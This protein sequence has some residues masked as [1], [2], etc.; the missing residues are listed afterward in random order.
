MKY[1]LLAICSVT[2]TSFAVAHIFAVDRGVHFKYSRVDFGFPPR[3]NAFMPE[4][5][6]A[7]RVKGAWMPG[8]R[9][10]FGGDAW[11]WLVG[12]KTKYP[13]W[14]RCDAE[15]YPWTPSERS[16]EIRARRLS[17]V[18]KS[19]RAFRTYKAQ[20]SSGRAGAD[21]LLSEGLR[22]PKALWADA[23]LCEGAGRLMAQKRPAHFDLARVDAAMRVLL[24]TT[25]HSDFVADAH[26][27]R[28]A[29]NYRLGRFDQ[30]VREYA[31]MRRRTTLPQLR[32]RA[33]ESERLCRQ[34]NGNRAD[35]AIASL[36]RLYTFGEMDTAALTSFRLDVGSFTPNDGREFWQ[37]LSG[38]PRLLSLYVGYRTDMT[39][40]N[41][42]LLRRVSAALSSTPAAPERTIVQARIAQIA[43]TLRKPKVAHRFAITALNGPQD[44]DARNLATFVLATLDWRAGRLTQARDAYASIVRRSRTSYLAPAA[45][46]NAAL[47][48]EKLG[49]LLGAM[50]G[51]DDLGYVLD[52]AYMADA[53]IPIDQLARYVR[54]RHA[55]RR[56]LLTFTLGMRY[57]RVGRFE[58]AR[59]TFD[60]L[61]N[62][63]IRECLTVDPELDYD[64][65]PTQDPR[66]T[67]RDLMHLS[68]LVR[69]AHGSEAK[70]QAMLDMANYYYAKRDL[71]LYCP[72]LW[73]GLRSQS[74]Q[75][76]W[77][78]QAASPEDRQAIRR[79]HEEHECYAV[80]VR[81]CR[82]IVRKYPRTRVAAHA[83]YRAGTA[84]EHL[85]N[86]SAY[87]R[88]VARHD[89]LLNGAVRDLRFAARSGEPPLSRRAAK[90]AQVFAE[91]RCALWKEPQW[92]SASAR[93]W[94]PGDHPE[95]ESEV[96]P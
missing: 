37:R 22:D 79:Y 64:I 89:D 15:P 73:N 18:Q 91:E 67:T 47:L 65:P 69:K 49:D 86:M 21:R 84:E 66:K 17:A 51:Y 27:W 32:A 30:A 72:R 57:L 44:V 87:W 40:V 60:R 55:H 23:C 14:E 94:D 10:V 12:Q 54:K 75:F 1:R 4:S 93:R 81:I 77:N 26:G 61:S 62:K 96:T 38:D 8:T 6:L 11:V 63:Q 48:N 90:Y 71:L 13:E 85:A 2:L 3:R 28:G 33:L 41:A 58:E 76:S 34:A 78:D 46:Q 36:R 35:A 5:P 80:T 9:Y 19:S 50:E 59:R 95:K 52:F 43:L 70:A 45:E 29:V 68:A 92:E 16:T 74:F 88:W 31:E 53:R 83:A 25:P 56:S 39:P 24:H 82:E 7:K 42:D 20:A